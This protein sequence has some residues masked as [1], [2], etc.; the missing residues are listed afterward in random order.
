MFVAD[1]LV[2]WLIG[3]LADAGFKKLTTLVR[4]TDQQRALRQAAAA[5][6]ER[7]AE[8]LALPGGGQAEQLAGAIG[9]VFRDPA[10]DAAVAVQATLLEVLQAGIADKL[11]VLDEPD[12][13][14]ARQSPTRLPRAQGGMLAETL[15][16]R[17]GSCQAASW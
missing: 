4:G 12:I 2:A 11:A 6:V 3:L 14:G 16:R 9:R 10:P 7:T 17:S 5:A 1:D 13:T 8:Q 15:E